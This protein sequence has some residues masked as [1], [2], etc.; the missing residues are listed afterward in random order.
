MDQSIPENLEPV[1]HCCACKR[2]IVLPSTAAAGSVVACPYCGT[3]QV[4]RELTVFVSEP[5]VEA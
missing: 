1:V 5:V 2:L 3:R 4:L